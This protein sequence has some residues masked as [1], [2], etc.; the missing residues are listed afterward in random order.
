MICLETI[1]YFSDEPGSQD[2]PVLFRYFYP[3]RGNFIALVSN[4]RSRRSMIKLARHFQANCDLPLEHLATFSVVPGVA[5]SDHLAFWRAGYQ[6]V[7]VTDTAF[8]RYPYYHTAQD[9]PDKLDYD[10][11]AL[12]TKGLCRAIGE[13]AKEPL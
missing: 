7:M 11:L 13:M 1:G 2:Y 12:V 10:R 8:Y 9:T 5:W 6:A 3:E 4:F